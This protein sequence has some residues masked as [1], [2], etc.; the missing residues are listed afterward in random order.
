MAGL[1]FRRQQRIQRFLNK[2]TWASHRN[3]IARPA[4][5][6]RSTPVRFEQSP[7]QSPCRRS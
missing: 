1:H 2:A 5:L 4:A 7:G 3:W 6:R